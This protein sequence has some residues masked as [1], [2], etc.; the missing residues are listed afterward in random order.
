MVNSIKVINDA[1]CTDTQLPL[2]VTF[3]GGLTELASAYRLEPALPS[4]SRR[5]GSGDPN[6]PTLV[7][8]PTSPAW[9]QAP[10]TTSTRI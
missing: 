7:P 2:I 9:A 8:H 10:S 5:S 4:G 6:T 3:G 1:L